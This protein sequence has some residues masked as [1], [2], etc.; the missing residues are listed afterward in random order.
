MVAKSCKARS[1]HAPWETLHPDGKI[2]TLTHALDS[3]YDDFYAEQPKVAFDSCEMGY[4][5]D[6]EGPQHVNVWDKHSFSD[7]AGDQQALGGHWSW[8][9]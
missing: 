8:Y 5:I 3:D 1:C 7:H 2:S 9:T 4:L 6:Y